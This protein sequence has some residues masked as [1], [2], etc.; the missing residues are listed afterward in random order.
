MID[1]VHQLIEDWTRKTGKRISV[2]L[3]LQTRQILARIAMGRSHVCI[4]GQ[5]IAEG[6]PG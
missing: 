3:W 6:A 5:T 4:R 1:E 2:F